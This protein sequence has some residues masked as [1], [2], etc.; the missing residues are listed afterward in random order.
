MSSTSTDDEDLEVKKLKAGPV[1]L[2]SGKWRCCFEADELETMAEDYDDL[3]L[4]MTTAEQGVGLKERLVVHGPGVTAKSSRRRRTLPVR[5]L[6]PPFTMFTWET[7]LRAAIA[8]VPPHDWDY[9]AGIYDDFC[10]EAVE[11]VQKACDTAVDAINAL[12]QEI[13]DVDTEDAGYYDRME[14]LWEAY[15]LYTTILHEAVARTTEPDMLA[16]ATWCV[17]VLTRGFRA[18]QI[19]EGGCG[20]PLDDGVYGE[21]FFGPTVPMGAPRLAVKAY[22]SQMM[23]YDGWSYRSSEMWH[24]LGTVHGAHDSVARALE[25]CLT[26][27]KSLHGPVPDKPTDA[28]DDRIEMHDLSSAFNASDDPVLPGPWPTDK[29]DAAIETI[30]NENAPDN[31][32]VVVGLLAHMRESRTLVR[33]LTGM[34]SD[35]SPNDK[36]LDVITFRAAHEYCRRQKRL[37]Y[38]R[39]FQRW[40]CLWRVTSFW[41]TATGK[42]QGALT[43]PIGKRARREYS[44]DMGTDAD[45]VM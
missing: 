23:L 33:S 32:E 26:A 7:P 24:A 37:H 12:G 27:F 4:V 29:I 40:F 44:Y 17:E 18:F 28:W 30:E 19:E 38:H 2:F 22:M 8:G 6:Q 21:R 10:K 39:L 41:T 3:K 16:T 13:G 5:N 42:S 15:K 45:A 36:S 14:P 25:R 11:P 1:L 9:H 34:T 31:P 43:G 35:D 20:W